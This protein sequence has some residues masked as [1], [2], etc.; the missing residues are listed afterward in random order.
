[1]FAHFYFSRNK[2]STC[3][4][5]KS[6]LPTMSPSPCPPYVTSF[7][8]SSFILH[9]SSFV[10]HPSSSFLVL[11][12]SSFILLC[13]LSSCSLHPSSSSFVLCLSLLSSFFALSLRSSPFALFFAFCHS[14]S[15]SSFTLHPSPFILHPSSSTGLPS[16]LC[17]SLTLSVESFLAWEH[18]DR[19]SKWEG[20][21]F[22]SRAYV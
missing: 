17:I 14:P 9:P 20:W 4:K 8:S 22:L 13:P 6:V 19:K 18:G 2:I 15:P 16:C 21:R 5:K 3:T 11:R 7:Y 12:P 1:M 10:L